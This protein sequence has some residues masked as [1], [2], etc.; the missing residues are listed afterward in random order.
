[1]QHPPLKPFAIFGFL[2]LLFFVGVWS[3]C[4]RIVAPTGGLKDTLGPELLFSSPRK[5]AVGIRSNTIIMVFDEWIAP[6]QINQ[7][8]LI[9]PV[10]DNPFQTKIKKNK[11]T[12]TFDK[13]LPD[14]TT[15]NLNFRQAIQDLTEQNKSK[16]LTLAFS[17]GPEID[18][19]AMSGTI[20][21]LFT[22]EKAADVT[23]GLW[24][25][26]DSTSMRQTLG[27]SQLD[28][29]NIGRQKPAYATKTGPDGTYILPN[30]RRGLYFAAAWADA[31][32]NLKWDG[33][34]ERLAFLAQ[35]SFRLVADTGL[36]LKLSAIDDQKP[37]ILRQ[38]IEDSV[39][40]IETNEGLAN[41]Y[42]ILEG[43]ADTL[44]AQIDKDKRE[45]LLYPSWPQADTFAIRVHLI[46]TAGLATDTLLRFASPKPK[47]ASKRKN[48]DADKA[49]A[50]P[51]TI[52]FSMSPATNASVVLPAKITF[53]FPEPIVASARKMKEL[54]FSKRDSA[55][56]A[57]P[58]FGFWNPYMTTYTATLSKM[59]PKGIQILL[60]TV[61]LR[62]VRGSVVVG[63]TLMLL[64]TDLETA[65]LI[66]GTAKSKGDKHIVQL[67]GEDGNTVL[68]ERRNMPTFEFI[69]LTPGNYQIRLVIDAND[70]GR[71]DPGSFMRR[72]Q[73][74]A[75]IAP[76]G[77]I[78]VKANWEVE[79]IEIGE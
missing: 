76:T 60:P 69:G 58:I 67:L 14:S 50:A 29:L 26:Y 73:P 49:P 70:N 47:A 54:V 2:C 21:H 22:A 51:K 5:G 74:E 15:L 79:G 56:K 6:N 3:G 1:M 24:L 66:R 61:G 55:S 68:A 28:T 19:I 48:D 78:K 44:P 53:S 65:G 12:I 45:F 77:P 42:G 27:A 57:E 34:A 9:S 10:L 37:K 18:T 71:W 35:P 20:T 41:G 30:L 59:T 63:D 40:R 13:P 75:I 8:L 38:R 33:K 43:K 52:G 72:R 32:N 17:T 31:N 39:A 7:Q 23:V 11:L 62:S 4:A 46:D 64:P 25:L 36:S 16:D